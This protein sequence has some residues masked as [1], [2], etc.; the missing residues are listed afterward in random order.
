MSHENSPSCKI[1]SLQKNSGEL[2]SSNEREADDKLMPLVTS[3]QHTNFATD[4]M[5]NPNLRAKTQASHEEPEDWTHEI[6]E[7]QFEIPASNENFIAELDEVHTVNETKIRPTFKMPSTNI[8]VPMFNPNAVDSDSELPPIKYN[9]KA[10]Q[11]ENIIVA[12]LKQKNENLNVQLSA[13]EAPRELSDQTRRRIY[14]A[15]LKLDALNKKYLPSSVLS[16]ESQ[17]SIDNTMQLR[18][19]YTDESLNNFLLSQLSKPRICEVH[20]DPNFQG[21]GLHIG[22]TKNTAPLIEENGI[23]KRIGNNMIRRIEPGSPAETGG[24]M[25]GDKILEINGQNVELLEYKEV[26]SK[27]KEYL[28][29]S[30]VIQL[31]VMN[32]IEYNLQRSNNISQLEES[33][34]KSISNSVNSAAQLQQSGN[35]PPATF[36]NIFGAE[37]K[38][39]RKSATNASN[40]SQQSDNVT[41]SSDAVRRT[42]VNST[43]APTSSSSV[44][45]HQSMNVPPFKTFADD[46]FNRRKSYRNEYSYSS[47]QNISSKSDDNTIKGVLPPLEFQGSRHEAF[48]DEHIFKKDVIKNFTANT[49]ILDDVSYDET[50]NWDTRGFQIETV[51]SEKIQEP[52]LDSYKVTM[53]PQALM[54]EPKMVIMD[55]YAITTWNSSSSSEAA[56]ELEYE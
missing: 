20:V 30:N 49:S 26:V 45:F 17:A 37:M 41:T 43:L 19:S 1:R 51:K 24:L 47:D 35:A 22:D 14:D 16:D 48:D 52:Q 11:S 50:R 38:N 13:D 21:L 46:E 23:Y 5:V 40:T 10:A 3:Q 55:K 53:P 44:Q 42:L 4:L 7:Y 12:L 9:N 29:S 18:E 34:R 6:R 25:P 56:S 39:R 2:N 36:A 28:K 27:I 8:N 54:V 33:T 31:K 32:S 15:K